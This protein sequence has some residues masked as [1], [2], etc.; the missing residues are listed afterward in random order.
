MMPRIVWEG[1]ERGGNYWSDY[2]GWDRDG[3]GIGDKRHFPNDIASYL[4]SRFPAVRLVL[5]S[6]AM[7]LLQGLETQFPVLR[8]PG[9]M[10]ARP[11]MRP[12]IAA[13]ETL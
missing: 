8:P 4:V 11:L 1:S 2:V 3:D 7:L 9:V 6:P 5:H 12:A 13:P 10:E